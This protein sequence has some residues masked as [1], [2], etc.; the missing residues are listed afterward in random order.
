ML[1]PVH[2]TDEFF[3]RRAAGFVILVD[4]RILENARWGME[5]RIPSFMKA[6]EA[7]KYDNMGKILQGKKVVYSS[8]EGGKKLP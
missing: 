6:Y 5:A 7:Y 3:K 4:A 2:G 1:F 8:K